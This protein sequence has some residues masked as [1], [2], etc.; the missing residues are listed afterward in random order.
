MLTGEAIV[1]QTETIGL[2]RDLINQSVFPIDKSLGGP[3]KVRY[4]SA[5]MM[6]YIKC[7]FDTGIPLQPQLQSMFL[8][9]LFAAKEFA[10]LQQLL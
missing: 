6:E 8:G 7:L 4:I 9:F 10:V 2:F 3:L 1:F 5:I